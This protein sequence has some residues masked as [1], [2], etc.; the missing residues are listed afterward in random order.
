MKRMEKKY[1][2]SGSRHW[3]SEQT[4]LRG[5]NNIKAKFEVA[6]ERV[7]SIENERTLREVFCTKEILQI[8]SDELDKKRAEINGRNCGFVKKLNAKN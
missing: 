3:E 6:E 4:S 7:S 5:K 1:W 8:L 2:E